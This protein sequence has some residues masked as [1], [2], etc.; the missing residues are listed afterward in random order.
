VALSVRLNGSTIGSGGGIRLIGEQIT[1]HGRIDVASDNLV[2]VAIGSPG[3]I[4]I[5]TPNY[6]GNL[7]LFPST[8]R[9]LPGSPPLIWPRDT[10]PVA[11]I[12]S[13]AGQPVRNDPIA[14][15][16]PIPSAPDADVN[17]QTDQDVEIVIETKNIVPNN[18]KV[19]ARVTARN[20]GAF[21]VPAT[22]ST[23]DTSAAIWIAT[24]KMAPG[25]AAIQ[26][27]AVGQ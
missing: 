13:V 1:G 15:L 5:E 10:A 8:I 3:R 17:F 18:A 9:V 21:L 23:G 25:F 4:R 27:R 11:R 24:T 22:F 19:N 12:V 14:N 7:Q 2:Q 16:A 6:T 26:A 20:G